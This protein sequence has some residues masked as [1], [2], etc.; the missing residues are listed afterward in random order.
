MTNAQGADLIEKDILP[1]WKATHEQLASV[2]DLPDD[3]RALMKVVLEYVGVREEA[4]DLM[5]QGMRANDD[6]LIRRGLDRYEV[7]TALAQAQNARGEK[8]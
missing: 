8:K 3:K 1:A 7:A 5:A 4:F 2:E 6:A